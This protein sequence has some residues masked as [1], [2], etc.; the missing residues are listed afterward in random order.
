MG[1][2]RRWVIRPR[3]QSWAVQE[4][5]ATL[6]SSRKQCLRSFQHTPQPPPVIPGYRAGGILRDPLSPRACQGNGTLERGCDVPTATEESPAEL[7]LESQPP[8]PEPG[9]GGAAPAPCHPCLAV[10]SQSQSFNSLISLLTGALE[11]TARGNG[12]SC[13]V[14]VIPAA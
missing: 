14:S 13:F 10:Q 3:S 12:K 11:V 7:R 8:T 4:P 9:S 6:R 2:R 1:I 5:G